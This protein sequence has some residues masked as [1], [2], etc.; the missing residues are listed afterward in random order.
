MLNSSPPGT[1]GYGQK[2]KLACFP[3]QNIINSIFFQ[4]R[5]MTLLFY[6]KEKMLILG[7]R[8]P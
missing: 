7:N 8:E 5:A 6:H 3:Y 1:E 4:N 2:Y